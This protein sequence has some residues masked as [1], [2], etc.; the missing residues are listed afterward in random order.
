MTALLHAIPWELPATLAG[1]GLLLAS[2]GRV[3]RAVRAAIAQ[4][5]PKASDWTP[6]QRFLAWTLV[7]LGAGITVPAFAE[8]YLTVTHVIHPAF[9][10]WSW[11]VP[12][13][14]EIA[15]TYL[16]I[17][18][19][20]LAMRRAPSGAFRSVL[21]AAIIAGSVILNVWAYLGSVPAVAGHLIIVAAFF[22]VLIAGKE[23]VMTLRGGKVKADRITAGEWIAHPR[24]SARLWRWQQ[25]WGETSHDDAQARFL[26]LLYVIAV[27]Q[28]HPAIGGKAGWRRKL[29]VTLRYELSMGLLPDAIADGSGD[30]QLAAREHVAGQ[31][32][33][34]RP[35]VP[36]HAPALPPVI[37]ASTPQ[38]QLPS[39]PEPL[40]RAIAEATPKQPAR[41]SLKLTAGKSRSMTAAAL[42]PHVAAMLDE[43]G[44]VGIPR[45][46]TD[47]HVG[48]EKATEALRLARKMRMSGQP[49]PVRTA[50]E[51]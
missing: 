51:G 13:S 6:A 49:E 50:A 25:V 1:A 7:A 24:H 39:K 2:L 18:G 11:T 28:A 48:T 47:L 40:P 37:A 21:M 3:G 38:E 36:E 19:V 10:A 4:R 16:F 9:G 41:P 17:N 46:K 44:T 33:P 32:D 45:V 15:F 27:T 12:V 14:G 22:G 23:T 5:K 34:L 29:P 26:V 35:A 43:Y 8:I 42:A 31:L 20:L 30:W